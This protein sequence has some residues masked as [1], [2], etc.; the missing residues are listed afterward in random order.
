MK[1]DKH[2]SR[3]VTVRKTLSPKKTGKPEPEIPGLTD[4][5]AL[6]IPSTES[7]SRLGAIPLLFD[8]PDNPGLQSG[9]VSYDSWRQGSPISLRDVGAGHIRRIRLSAGSISLEIVAELG[10]RRWEFVARVYHNEVV[11]HEYVLKAGGRSYLASAGGYFHWDSKS[12]PH[13][14]SLL[15]ADG[16]IEF[17]RLAWN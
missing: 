10:H 3:K 2:R 9:E 12:V 4:S 14:L 7:I 8:L 17:E 11:S 5:V 13:Q 1:Q 15:S 16:R 6:E